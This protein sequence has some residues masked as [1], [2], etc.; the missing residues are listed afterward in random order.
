MR[1]RSLR[2][3]NTLCR[4]GRRRSASTIDR[5]ESRLGHRDR[6]IGGDGGFA[7]TG[8]GAG[9]GERGDWARCCREIRDSCARA[10]GF[11][12]R[13]IRL[14]EQEELL[15]AG[16]HVLNRDRPPPVAVC[17]RA[18]GSR[19]STSSCCRDTRARPRRRW[20]YRTQRMRPVRRR[21]CFG[22][23]RAR[24]ARRPDRRNSPA[25]AR[26]PAKAHSR[27]QRWAPLHTWSATD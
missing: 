20:Q 23:R 6:E 22:V 21:A 27:W 13:R 26:P 14:F 17:R 10:D 5:G 3:P 2:I 9:D 11:S 25:F 24:S 8:S 1:P 4:V 16:F 15:A 19:D 18:S 7:F 12:R